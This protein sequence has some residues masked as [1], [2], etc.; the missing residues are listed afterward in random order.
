MARYWDPEYA[1]LVGD[2]GETR[3]DVVDPGPFLP[4]TAFVVSCVSIWAYRRLR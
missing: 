1:E 3:A 2:I 4:T